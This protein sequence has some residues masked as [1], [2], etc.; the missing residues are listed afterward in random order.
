MKLEYMDKLK[1]SVKKGAT[2]MARVR[3]HSLKDLEQMLGSFYG[4]YNHNQLEDNTRLHDKT[5][6]SCGIPKNTSSF[7]RVH[8]RFVLP[9][10]EPFSVNASLFFNRRTKVEIISIR[11]KC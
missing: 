9:E 5:V 11:P 7:R 4:F 10:R 1:Q 3:L 2:S 8:F 6:S